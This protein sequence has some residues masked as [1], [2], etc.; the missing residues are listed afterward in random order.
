MNK[1]TNYVSMDEAYTSMELET[2]PFPIEVF[3]KSIQQIIGSTKQCLNFPTDFT[4]ASILFAVSLAIG[5]T[6]RILVS[7]GW[8]ENAVLFIA[9]VG[10]PGTNKSHPLSFILQPIFDRQG[11]T[12][13]EYEKK[14]KE[15]DKVFKL[16]KDERNQQGYDEPV[17]PFWEKYTITDYT[18]EALNEVHKHNKRGIGVYSDELAGWLKNFNRYHKGAE[19]EFWLSVWSN[20]TINIDRITKEPIYIP[21]P[22][23]PVVGNIQPSILFE[24]SKNSRAQNGFIHRLLFAF[25]EGLEKLCWSDMKLKPVVAENWKQII[26]NL[27]DLPLALNENQVPNPA[28]LSFNQEASNKIKEWQK[29]NTNL[30]NSAED[31][32]LEGIYTKLEIYAIRFSLI[33]EMLR[34]ACGEGD[35]QS[36]G[37]EAVTGAIQLVEYFRVTAVKVNS[38][39]CN[40]NPLDKQPV[41][42]QKLYELLPLHFTRDTGLKIVQSIGF[43]HATYDRFLT[44]NTLFKKVKTGEYEKTM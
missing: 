18:P 4:G 30:C 11:K 3:P 32:S 10:R 16:S 28:V 31:E 37:I 23:I 34:F 27:L 24:L 2:N 22:F 40:N 21:Y 14:K 8:E 1:D 7:N 15:F 19:Q 5:N 39:I 41:D 20:K 43:S 42:K 29:H 6:Y 13:T 26:S 17:R 35:K 33:L 38:I 44:D 25:P 9:N 36:I 12:Y